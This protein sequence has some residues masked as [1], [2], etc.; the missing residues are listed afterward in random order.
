MRSN[1]E[2]LRLVAFRS[3]LS[4]IRPNAQCT[5]ELKTEYDN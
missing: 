1:Y 3:D 5:H 2:H 4:S